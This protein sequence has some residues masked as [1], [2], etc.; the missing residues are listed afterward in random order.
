LFVA[1]LT[2]RAQPEPI[3]AEREH[4]LGVIGGV[5]LPSCAACDD[6]LPGPAVSG[7][8]LGGLTRYVLF[9]GIVERV[10]FSYRRHGSSLGREDA[11]TWFFAPLLRVLGVREHTLD[12]HLDLGFGIGT[13][14]TG[15][16]EAQS[17]PGLVLGLGV[18][19]RLLEPLK[20]GPYAR[21]ALIFAGREQSC[22]G[23]GSCPAAT[24]AHA[25]YG[26]LGLSAALALPDP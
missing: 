6:E 20:I 19:W 4:E 17:G 24:P 3:A 7:L 8:L 16:T 26:M 22:G 15:E 14:Q 5:A 21:A 10:G 11:S 18:R 23:V 25:G 2:A 1:S 12:A 9:G 13:S